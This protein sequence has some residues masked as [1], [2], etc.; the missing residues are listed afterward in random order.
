MK[1]NLDFYIHWIWTATFGILALS[2]FALMG[3]R[4]G[5]IMNYALPAADYLHRTLA[6]IY[7]LLLAAAIILEILRLQINFKAG[8]WMM[9][10][11]GSY[12]VFTLI[13]T[14]LLILSGLFIWICME[15]SMEA[16]T[17]SMMVHEIV[18]YLATGSILWHI[19][20]KAHVLRL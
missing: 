4:F 17:F 14:L 3:A 1:L 2:G 13:T 9:V 10:G 8:I 12:Q 19:Y 11:I 6:A 16:L 20:K 5:W 15:W 18:A 7:T